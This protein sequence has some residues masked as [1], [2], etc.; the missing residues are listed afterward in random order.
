MNSV[1]VF[2]ANLSIPVVSMFRSSILGNDLFHALMSADVI[3]D[4]TNKRKRETFENDVDRALATANHKLLRCV[5][6]STFDS[7]NCSQLRKKCK[8]LYINTSKF[9][10]K[11]EYT[12]ALKEKMK[13]TCPICLE[14]FYDGCVYCITPCGHMY[15]SDCIDQHIVSSVGRKKGQFPTCAICLRGLNGK[16]L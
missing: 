8:D 5:Y 9:I 4:S 13:D 6:V 2:F 7:F 1:S 15:H 14:E 16:T 10:E 11:S 12:A 3:N